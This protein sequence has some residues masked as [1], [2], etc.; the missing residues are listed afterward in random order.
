MF[1]SDAAVEGIRAGTIC[2]LLREADTVFLPVSILHQRPYVAVGLV[3]KGHRE[4]FVFEASQ[5]LVVAVEGRV[6][7]G[8]KNEGCGHCLSLLKQVIF[9][10]TSLST[11][12]AA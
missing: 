9:E 2:A 5:G 12:V 11:C 1:A 4:G 10:R 6:L 3:G 7:E 8:R